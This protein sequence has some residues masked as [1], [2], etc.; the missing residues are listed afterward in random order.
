M[1][2]RTD[3]QCSDPHWRGVMSGAAQLRYE[4]QM[5]EIR[6]DLAADGV[7]ML[8]PVTRAEYHRACIR[9]IVSAA[10]LGSAIVALP[11]LWALIGGALAL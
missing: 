9:A 5:D 4:A 11:V 6:R 8:R 7:P 3:Y 2:A 10:I 1:N